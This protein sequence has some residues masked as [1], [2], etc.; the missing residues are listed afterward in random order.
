V[1]SAPP[2]LTAA[3][4]VQSLR[5][6]FESGRLGGADILD[7]IARIAY[8][9]A[10]GLSGPRRLVAFVLSQ[11]LFDLAN[12]RSDRPVSQD[13]NH[14]VLSEFQTLSRAALFI[15][16][17]Q[18]DAAGICDALLDAFFRLMR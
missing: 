14:A 6:A 1:S 7:E 15:N 5:Q 4:L 9:C 10:E 17:S 12:D 11:A 8:S 13:E 2:S 16:G 3:Q 18:D